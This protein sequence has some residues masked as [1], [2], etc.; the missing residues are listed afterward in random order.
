ME[1]E[2]LLLENESLEYHE[3]QTHAPKHI[4]VTREM[5]FEEVVDYASRKIDVAAA[6]QG[7]RKVCT[8]KTPIE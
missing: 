7:I 3:Q 6:L 4:E 5:T 2:D 8:K 1:L